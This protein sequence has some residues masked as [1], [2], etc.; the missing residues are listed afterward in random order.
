ML[1]SAYV[2]VCVTAE[3]ISRKKPINAN[4]VDGS[5][6]D[7]G[8]ENNALTLLF[9]R[10][11]RNKW[12]KRALMRRTAFRMLL[13]MLNRKVV[14]LTC[15]ACCHKAARRKLRILTSLTSTRKMRIFRIQMNRHRVESGRASHSVSFASPKFSL[16]NV[17]QFFT[18]RT[19]A[20]FRRSKFEHKVSAHLINHVVKC[21]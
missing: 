4:R 14:G 19:F 15:Y 17:A 8:V 13:K 6:V 5:V 2:C 9:I 10:H 18:T 1:L 11:D 12:S 3:S 16:R 21:Y 20:P 7:K